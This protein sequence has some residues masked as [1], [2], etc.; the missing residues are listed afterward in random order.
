MMVSV[1][2]NGTGQRAQIDGYKVGGKTGTAQNA[3]DATR[4]RLVH[5]V[6]ADK[7]GK[8]VSAVCVHAG[9]RPAAAAAPRRPGSPGRSCR[10]RSPDAAEV[11]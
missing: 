8:P 11:S 2:E 6:R 5:R 7:D 4:P 10:R 3:A 1:V 9:E